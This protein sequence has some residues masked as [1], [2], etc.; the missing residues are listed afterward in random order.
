MTAARATTQQRPAPLE[1][2]ELP[3]RIKRARVRAEFNQKELAR[4]S[5]VPAA[6]I[7]RLENGKRLGNV[8]ARVL[9]DLAH[10]LR[11][12]VGWL[13]AG[14][15]PPRPSAYPP[16]VE[17]SIPPEERARILRELEDEG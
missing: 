11:V 15:L 6:V 4:A 7:S 17:R 16:V 13:A 8:S 3:G 5:G 12:P 2:L 9:I 14:E 1:L 10:A